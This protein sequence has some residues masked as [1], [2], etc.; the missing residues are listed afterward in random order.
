VVEHPVVEHGEGRTARWLRERRLKIA[1]GIGVIESILVLTSQIRWFW[2]LGLFLVLAVTYLYVRRRFENEM[3]RQ[4]TWT[5]AFSQVLPFVFPLLWGL[6][7]AVA[8]VV[9][10]VVALVA[11]GLLFLD[12]R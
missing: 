5:A 3:L 7:K 2:V 4:I 9:L 6:F 1:L 8:I 12:R 10:V 11:A